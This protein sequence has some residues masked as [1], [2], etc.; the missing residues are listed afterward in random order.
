MKGK[1]TSLS[2]PFEIDF[3]DKSLCPELREARIGMSM[4]PGRV[5]RDWNRDLEADLA[6]I[7]EKKV[8]VVASIITNTELRQMNRADFYEK[9]KNS[10]L[11]SLE[12]SIHD[13]WLPNS[14]ENFNRVVNTILEHLQQ[15]KTVLVHCNG[16]RGRTG[17]VVAA[18]IYNLGYSIDQAIHIVRTARSG[19]LR[20]PAQEFFLRSVV[21]KSKGGIFDKS[22]RR[23]SRLVIPVVEP[24]TPRS[25]SQPSS[26][27]SF[28]GSPRVGTNSPRTPRFAISC[29]KS[30]MRDPNAEIYSEIIPHRMTSVLENAGASV[31]IPI[32]VSFSPILAVH[33]ELEEKNHN[34]EDQ[35]QKT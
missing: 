31:E 6:V 35:T 29:K 21:S 26:P 3:I 22:P 12:L 28:G 25:L 30:P 13:K 33:L 14:V 24:L 10:Q 17:L 34:K 7:L 27:R 20:N 32:D 9:V 19:M 15:D 11:E 1:K 18:C 23:L 8:N 5:W 16:G 4:C 2:H